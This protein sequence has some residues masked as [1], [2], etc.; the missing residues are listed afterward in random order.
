M[1]KVLKNL[2][3]IFL[4]VVMACG[5][6]ALLA[7]CG[8]KT[9][10][11]DHI[12]ITYFYGS[13]IPQDL[14][15]VEAA[16]SAY[17]QE[18]IGV[19][20]EFYPVSVYNQDYTKIVGVDELDLMCVAFGDPLTYAEY[21]IV[22]NIEESDLN[23]FAPELMEQNKSQDI[24]V[25]N[26]DGKIIG[27]NTREKAVIWG[28]SY[29]VRSS[30]LKKCP[31]TGEGASD[32]DGDG[33]VTLADKY[34]NGSRI[35]Y[36]Q[37]E[38]ILAAIKQYACDAGEYPLISKM[39]DSGYMFGSDVLGDKIGVLNFGFEDD[40][41]NKTTVVNYYETKEWQDY[42]KFMKKAV[43]NGWIMKDAVTSPVNKTDALKNG[44]AKGGF[45]QPCE[46]MRL[47]QQTSVGEELVMLLTNEPYFCPLRSGGCM[48]GLCGTSDKVESAL[49]FLNL[50]WTDEY[51]MNTIQW[52]LEGEHYEFVDDD[53][54]FITFPEGVNS[55]NSGFYMTAGFYGDKRYIY[56]F[57]GADSTYTME[58]FL[59]AEKADME[60]S[61]YNAVHRAS[62]AGS[63][64]YNSAKNKNKI[65]NISAIIKE[66]SD[67]LAC[68]GYTDALYNEFIQ[69]LKG[70]GI[71]EIIADKQSQLD[72]YLNAL[73]K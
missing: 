33:N 68:G 56:N 29:M 61:D 24:L 31:W 5:S 8:K 25:R 42:C 59:A 67:N 50:F 52:G 10:D 12:V 55:E 64:I 44:T 65:T 41:S 62:P 34:R 2:V 40:I 22:Q 15:K 43:D 20:V 49:K 17:S 35:D 18:K 14:D 60:T 54:H 51:V 16:V 66:Y 71:D 19:S 38:E 7:S 57:I 72:A 13:K 9:V 46:T 36:T 30:S 48:W 6:M 70:A 45:F 47:N 3:C 27:V 63:F 58:D 37:F 26:A 32:V 11:D 53:H 1:K 4:A 23:K 28:G 39:D 21:E 73:N 69:K